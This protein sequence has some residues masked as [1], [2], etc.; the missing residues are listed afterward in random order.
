MNTTSKA[1]LSVALLVPALSG[2]FPF[3]RQAQALW[4]Q[5]PSRQALQQ[6]SMHLVNNAQDFA[7][8]NVARVIHSDAVERAAFGLAALQGNIAP[9]CTKKVGAI[10]AAAAAVTTAGIVAYKN[11][12]FNKAANK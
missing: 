2:A 7:Q 10:A 1:I 8:R 4:A 9:Y 6:R 12:I 3:Q 11:G 5:C